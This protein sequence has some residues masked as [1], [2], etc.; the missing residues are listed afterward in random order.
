MK[1]GC[2]FDGIITRL[3]HILE[4]NGITDHIKQ[5]DLSVFKMT[6]GQYQQ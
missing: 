2:H 6:Q 3:C 1:Y 5:I 4:V